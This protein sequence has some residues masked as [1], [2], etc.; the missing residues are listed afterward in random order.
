MRI[1]QIYM[2]ELAT[3]VKFK[4]LEP[5]DVQTFLESLSFSKDDKSES[6]YYVLYRK[7]I[8][9]N[10]IFN[11]KGDITES[12]RLMSRRAAESCLDALY[13]GCIML[14]PGLDVD[15]W[16]ALSYGPP[17]ADKEDDSNED[18]DFSKAFL[19]SLKKFKKNRKQKDGYGRL[20]ISY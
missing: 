11:L 17:M 14:N 9:E 6:E 15:S 20:S 2:P 13:T 19:D 5:E 4:V 3:F 8:I 12:L 10:F 16:V 7:S 1:Y 18:D